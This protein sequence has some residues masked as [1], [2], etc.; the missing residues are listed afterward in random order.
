MALNGAHEGA[1]ARSWQ[2][3]GA[4]AMALLQQLKELGRGGRPLGNGASLHHSTSGAEL[5]VIHLTANGSAAAA[6]PPSP[7]PAQRRAATHAHGAGHAGFPWPHTLLA[8]R[9]RGLVC[10]NLVCILCASA[11][12]VLREVE[13]GLDAW[14]FNGLRFAVAA[15]GMSPYWRTAVQDE[16]VVRAGVDIGFWAAAGYLTQSLGLITGE[17]SR[18]AF[19]S[20]MTV[21]V[22]PIIAAVLG[23]ARLKRT[24]W[25][26]VAASMVGIGLLEDSGAP[27]AIG[28]LWSFASAVLFGMQI[29]RA[30]VWSKRLGGKQAMPILS[31]TVLMVCAVSLLSMLVVHSEAATQ[32]LWVPTA[33]SAARTYFTGRTAFAVV[34]MGLGVTVGGL[35]LE[36]IAL[37]DITSTEAAIIYSSEPL[38][39]AGMAYLLLNERW[40]LGG[41]VG[42]ALIIASCLVAQLGTSLEK[43]DDDKLIS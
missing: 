18:G 2:A 16:R 23:D 7:T 27:A 10:L 14:V 19:L 1:W 3:P 6:R 43:Q 31:V 42:A 34:Y 17:A 21:V 4:S 5:E 29:W 13:K 37:Q 26:A 36:L 38:W 41:W 32:L 22:T 12:T 30:E 25:A 11:F 9:V 24:A 33:L 28:D 15:A 35:W 39:G 20:G 40:G 8:P